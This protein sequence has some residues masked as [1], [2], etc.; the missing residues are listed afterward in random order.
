MDTPAPAG[1]AS[2]LALLRQPLARRADA[3]R[4]PSRTRAGMLIDIE[5][6]LWLA[7]LVEDDGYIATADE[8]A[9]YRELEAFHRA[10]YQTLEPQDRDWLARGLDARIATWEADYQRQRSRR[11]APRPAALQPVAA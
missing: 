6:R 5:R 8:V 11:A 3:W 1:A 7:G 10:A 2:L 4:L 9:A